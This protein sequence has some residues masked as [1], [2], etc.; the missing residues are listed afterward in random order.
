[1]SYSGKSYG[2]RSNREEKLVKHFF[3]RERAKGWCEK[4]N[5]KPQRVVSIGEVN[6]KKILR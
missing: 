1:M 6:M 5:Y 4:G 3:E 2:L